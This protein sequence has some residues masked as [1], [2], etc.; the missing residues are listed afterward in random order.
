MADE[1][2]SEG[3]SVSYRRVAYKF[4]SPGV[5]DDG[6]ADAERSYRPALVLSRTISRMREDPAAEDRR[7]IEIVLGGNCNV[8]FMKPGLEAAVWR[9]GAPPPVRPTP[10]DD[11][12]GGAH[13]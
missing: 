4:D 9:D 2:R 12:G 7:R 11:L 6:D 10:P 5:P 1:D 13:L 3:V 8:E